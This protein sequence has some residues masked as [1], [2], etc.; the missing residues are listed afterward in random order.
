MEK[1]FVYA[2]NAATTALSQTALQAMLPY[3]TEQYGNASS[4]YSVGRAAKRGLDQAR[5]KVA[6]AIGAQPEEIYFCSGGTEADNWV[7][8]GIAAA[9]GSKGKHMIT[10]AVEHH[11]ILHTAAYL[12]KNGYEVTYLPVDDQGR[13]SLEELEQAIREDTIL[14]SV[15]TANNEIGTILPIGE[16]GA[17][18]KAHGVPFPAGGVRP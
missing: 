2:D 12:E 3:L 5:A 10:T 1:R 9:R 6:A 8:K 7:L 15:M 18:A 11:A 4:I 17:I 13:I 14:I 16:I